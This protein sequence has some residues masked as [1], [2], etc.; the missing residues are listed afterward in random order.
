MLYQE[1]STSVPVDT[2]IIVRF[3]ESI[4][5]SDLDIYLANAEDYQEVKGVVFVREN[6]IIFTPVSSLRY[7]AIYVVVIS[8]GISDSAGN[9]KKWELIWG[10]TTIFKTK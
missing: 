4:V 7:S 6:E 1:R 8:A 5:T 9:G 2:K 10:F 3:D